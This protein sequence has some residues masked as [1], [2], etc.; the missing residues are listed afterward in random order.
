MMNDSEAE[1]KQP[2]LRGSTLIR[3]SFKILLCEIWRHLVVRRLMNTHFHLQE[4]P[5]LF[6]TWNF[7]QGRKCAEYTKAAQWELR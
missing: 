3:C 2:L 1:F 4:F 5:N 6:L 7:S